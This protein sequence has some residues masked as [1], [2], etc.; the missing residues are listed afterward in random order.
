MGLKN[1]QWQHEGLQISG[2]Y[3]RITKIL[4]EA[5]GGKTY[6]N[7]DGTIA[8]RANMQVKLLTYSNQNARNAMSQ[9]LVEEDYFVSVDLTGSI[10]NKGVL[11]HVYD[12]LKVSPQFPYSGSAHLEN[13]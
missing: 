4:W 2:S 5:N 8:E 12:C 1:N 3:A 6:Y 10:D 9:S 7:G 11:E 13:V